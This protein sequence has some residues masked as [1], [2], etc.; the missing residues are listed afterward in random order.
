M[1][2]VGSAI[3][4]F[5]AVV[6]MVVFCGG[7]SWQMLL[8]FPSL[9]LL[10]VIVIPMLCVSGLGKD[11]LKAI[12]I[13]GSKKETTLVQINRSIEAVKLAMNTLLYS[14]IFMTLFSIMIIFGGQAREG[15][16]AGSLLMNCEVAM[17]TLV[18][19]L[20]LCLILLPV[21]AALKRRKIDYI[22][23]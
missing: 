10:A 23:D 2:T 3:S 15:V 14:G 18:Y 16:D 22:N 4:V 12:S 20:A 6:L 11:F 7:I 19:A 21:L 17:I 9:V 13:A 8:D 5:V 1:V